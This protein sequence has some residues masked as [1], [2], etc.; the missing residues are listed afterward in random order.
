MDFAKIIDSKRYGQVVLID[1]IGDVTPNEP[2]NLTV[3]LAT[4]SAIVGMGM[5]RYNII[6]GPASPY[7]RNL[8]SE[9][10]DL[11]KAEEFI[12]LLLKQNTALPQKFADTDQERP[13]FAKSFHSERY[14]QIV[15]IQDGCMEAR[16]PHIQIRFRPTRPTIL[17]GMTLIKVAEHCR[18]DEILQKVGERAAV[19]AKFQSLDLAKVEACVDEWVKKYPK[20]M[21]PLT[22]T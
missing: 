4:D 6:D 12:G 17:Q 16:D 15:A 1:D 22:F 7:L 20:D 9:E 2:G 14:G 11:R 19:R 8:L 21:P 10:P 5:S 18:G 3:Y 13:V